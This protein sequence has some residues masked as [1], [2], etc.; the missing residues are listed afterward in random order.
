MLDNPNESKPKQKFF[1]KE[2]LIGL[3]VSFIAT[4][5][6]FALVLVIE[7]FGVNLKFETDKYLI[8]I[9]SFT[10]SGGLSICFYA[11]VVLTSFGA[12]DLISYSIQLSWY[13]VFH[14]DLRKS[15]LPSSFHEYRALK[16][17]QEKRRTSFM[18]LGSLPYLITGIILCIPYYVIY[19]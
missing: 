11:L 18:L 13:T 5:V 2:Y 8:L 12:F 3:L 17:S 4:G 7:L 6:M 1:D 10:V 15:K 19:R 16:S 14:K 9:N